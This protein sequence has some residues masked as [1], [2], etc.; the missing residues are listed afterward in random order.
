[1]GVKFSP[2]AFEK[3]EAGKISKISKHTKA[4]GD[5]LWILPPPPKIISDSFSVWTDLE[6]KSVVTLEALGSSRPSILGSSH[7][8]RFPEN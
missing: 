3:E 5:F 2:A 4:C 7:K 8:G 1:M 6:L